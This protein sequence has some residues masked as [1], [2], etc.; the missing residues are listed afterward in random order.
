MIPY[1]MISI[2]ILLYRFPLVNS[3]LLIVKFAMMNLVSA[4]YKDIIWMNNNNVNLNVAMV[5]LHKMNNV[6]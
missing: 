3:V 5:F 6:K 4:V 1:G 2:I